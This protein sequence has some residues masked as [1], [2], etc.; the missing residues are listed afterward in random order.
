MHP[1]VSNYGTPEQLLTWI[2]QA[3]EKAMHTKQALQT[4]EGK[5]AIALYD[6]AIAMLSSLQEWWSETHVYLPRQLTHGDYGGGNILFRQE[7]I[8][9]ILDFDFLRVRERVYELAYSLY[10]W[11]WK[12]GKLTDIAFWPHV[13]ELLDTY[14]QAVQS[15]LSVKEM[16]SISVMMICVP[17]YW[18]AETLLLP[19]P[20]QEVIKQEQKVADARWLFVNREELIELLLSTS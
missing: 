12:L 19:E 11:L 18:I 4:S 5:Y 2:Q 13:K 14:N 16:Q 3:R 15:P 9:A 17:L 1:V 7:H 10:W 6:D 20:M 8:V